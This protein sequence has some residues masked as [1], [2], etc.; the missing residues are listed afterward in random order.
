MA[1]LS[2]FLRE[3]ETFCEQARTRADSSSLLEGVASVAGGGGG[4]VEWSEENRL[5]CGKARHSCSKRKL[6]CQRTLLGAIF[7]VKS[8]M[9]SGM[10]AVPRQYVGHR[11]KNPSRRASQNNPGNSSA[12]AAS[13]EIAACC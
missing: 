13:V 9:E 8:P 5:N 6:L 10:G 7:H 12:P 4:V 2:S 3:G 1:C 11:P